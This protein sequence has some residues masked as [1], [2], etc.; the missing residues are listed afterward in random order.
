[1]NGLQ[2]LDDLNDEDAALF[3]R[4]PAPIDSNV[5]KD[6]S[7]WHLPRKQYIRI[8]QWCREVAQ[9]AREITIGNGKTFNYLTLPGDD[10]L[11]I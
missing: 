11:D 4:E 5:K 8:H 3:H 9:L 1:M 7:Q 6:F 10:L 2:S